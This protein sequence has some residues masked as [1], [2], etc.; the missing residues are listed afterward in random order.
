MSR[1]LSCG[2]LSFALVQLRSGRGDVGGQKGFLLSCLAL[3]NS[4]KKRTL[5]F[6][7][8]SQNSRVK[9]LNCVYKSDNCWETK[10][11]MVE[12]LTLYFP[13]LSSCKNRFYVIFSQ[14][15]NGEHNFLFACDMMVGKEETREIISD[16][17]EKLVSFLVEFRN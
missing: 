14:Y 10:S 11:F 5:Q 16:G 6:S 13:F 3:S 12:F 2:A 4:T 9:E 17:N 15:C 8:C 1:F 7:V